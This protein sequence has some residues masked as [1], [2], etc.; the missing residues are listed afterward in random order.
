MVE[1][2]LGGYE[3]DVPAGALAELGPGVDRVLIDVAE[4]V[5]VSRLRR[6]RALAALG[7]VPSLGGRDYL[8]RRLRE[9]RGAAEGAEL[10]ELVACMRALGRFGPE[11]AGDLV[12]LLGHAHP[13]ARAAAALSLGDAGAAEMAAPLVRRLSVESDRGVREALRRVLLGLRSR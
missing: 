2:L 5:A 8:R 6:A 1:G 4:D 10:L 9:L 3:P 11:G 13:E 12:R 7:S